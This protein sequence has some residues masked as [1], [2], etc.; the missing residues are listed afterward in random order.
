VNILRGG[1]AVGQQPVDHHRSNAAAG[2]ERVTQ[3]DD[4]ARRV[5]T[6]AK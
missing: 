4:E 3:P 1:I 6:V 2:F 5:P